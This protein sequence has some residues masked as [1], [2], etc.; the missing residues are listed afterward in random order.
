MNAP[1]YF[2]LI[3]SRGWTAEQY[4]ASHLRLRSAGVAVGRDESEWVGSRG[5]LPL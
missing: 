3:M 4:A 1:E 5:W 2:L